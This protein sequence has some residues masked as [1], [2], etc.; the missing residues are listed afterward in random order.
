MDVGIDKN[1]AHRA[2]TLG[3]LSDEEF[4]AAVKENR[5]RIADEADRITRRT[6][7]VAARKST[8]SRQ[9]VI[10]DGRYGCIVIDPPWLME[11]IEREVRPNQ[12]GFEYPTM[13]EDEL[14]AFDMAEFAA[15]H[16]HLWCWTTHRFLPMAFRL[17]GIWG[18]HYVCTFVWHKPGGYQPVGLP[19][20]NCEFALYARCGS[21]SFI[22]TKAFNTCFEAPRREHS[23][24][25]E[26]FYETVRRVTAG[27]R[28]DVFSR[29]KH[30]GFTQYGNETDKFEAAQ[31]SG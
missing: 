20:Y 19:Q 1:L 15:D 10:P 5:A 12:V 27:P 13:T 17:V 26:E 8:E 16:C 6:I 14:S 11:K 30:N 18:F 2:R 25:P 7:N 28:L 4:E 9:A 22:D 3:G 29:E 21:P 31:L 23:R 24:K